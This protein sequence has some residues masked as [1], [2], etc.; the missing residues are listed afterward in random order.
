MIL[1]EIKRLEKLMELDLK[2]LPY[3]TMEYGY[4]TWIFEDART[5]KGSDNYIHVFPIGFTKNSVFVINPK[6]KDLKG[7]GLCNGDYQGHRSEGYIIDKLEDAPALSLE[8]YKSLKRL[9][10]IL[11][12]VKRN[13]T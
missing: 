6:T 10:D 11:K 12:K 1:P 2:K 8:D 4:R 7:H 3:L 5:Y 13:G 9:K